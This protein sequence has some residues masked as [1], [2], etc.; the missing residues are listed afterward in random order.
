MCA[1]PIVQGSLV[2]TP[3]G[4]VKMDP[5]AFR[6]AA[7]APGKIAQA[8]GEDVG[9]FFQDVSQKLQANFNAQQV[10]K[11]DI[12]LRNT[13][14]QFTADLVNHPDP[15][16]WLPQ[17][18]DQVAAQK[19][20]ILN[21]PKNGPQVKRQ[22]GMMVGTWEQATTSEIKIQALRKQV[23][24]T[25][26]TAKIAAEK[27]AQDG[28]I[29]EANNVVKAA[30]ENHADPV[31]MKNFASG[32]PRVAA[33]SQALLVIDN[34]PGNAP[35]IL[36]NDDKLQKTM[37]PV[38]FNSLLGVAHER[39]NQF[40]SSN[41]NDTREEIQAAGGS[42]DPEVLKRKVAFHQLTQRMADSLTGLMRRENYQNDKGTYDFARTMVQDHDWEND[43]K[44]QDFKRQLIETF[45]IKNDALSYSLGQ[46]IDTAI[47]KA[48]NNAAKEEKPVESQ[49]FSE[50]KE[51]REHNG[52]TTPSTS[53]IQKGATHWFSANEPDKVVHNQLLGGLAALRNPEKMS[54]DE[55]QKFFGQGVKREDVI[56]AE[57]TK[58]N[59]IQEKMR[60][61]FSDPNNKGADYDQARDYL[62]KLEAPYVMPA[63]TQ[64]IKQASDK[65]DAAAAW[66]MANPNDP[67][68]AAIKAKLGIK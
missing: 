24:D 2:D 66:V 10:F 39:Q 3:I 5:S 54:D 43:Q 25:T 45:G 60:Q 18:K 22:L 11:A 34:N 4:G 51:D 62:R 61:W 58:Y 30:I 44:P 31:D 49:I 27:Y 14:D 52:Y 37:G 26:T 12:A 17:W 6:Q 21:D 50:L 7:L 36:K 29:E 23:A 57:Q 38:V 19:D 20:A 42:I 13:K 67:R 33:K 41:Y 65:K 53:E 47:S 59:T 28:H 40:Y 56:R 9:G 55:I 32:L 63:A 35:E 15:G 8:V 64:Q 68:A 16:T 48:K 1:L 46:S